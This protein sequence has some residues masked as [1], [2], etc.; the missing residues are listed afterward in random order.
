MK[1]EQI[2]LLDPHYANAMEFAI[3]DPMRALHDATAKLNDVLAMQG[4]PID[5]NTSV[6]DYIQQFLTLGDGYEAFLEA[7]I[8]PPHDSFTLEGGRTVPSRFLV[9]DARNPQDNPD[10]TDLNPSTRIRAY[11]LLLG[12]NPLAAGE[13]YDIL[14]YF[15]VSQREITGKGTP[16]E[17]L[18]HMASNVFYARSDGGWPLDIRTAPQRVHETTPYEV[19]ATEMQGAVAKLMP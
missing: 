2:K 17:T 14:P 19:M 4:E 1:P 16:E 7:H 3:N 11:F 6:F 12:E 10:S 9:V 18:H 15:V 13:P 8:L 5:V